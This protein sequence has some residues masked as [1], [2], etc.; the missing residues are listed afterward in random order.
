MVNLGHKRAFTLVELLVVIAIVGAL[1]GLLLPAVQA[2]RE[3]ARRMQCSNHM[4]QI[5]LAMHNYHSA[6]NQLPTGY[7]SFPT[8]DGTAPASMRLDSLTW[9]AGPGWGWGA[10]ILPFLEQTALAEQIRYDRPLWDPSQ[11]ELISTK[12][13]TFLCPS[14]SDGDDAFTVQSESGAPLLI[15]GRQIQLGRS[16]YVVSHGQES[17]WDECGA[18]PEGIV[19]DNIYTGSVRTVQINGDTSR[20]ADGPFYRNSKI[21]IRDILDGTTYTIFAGEHSSMIAHKTWVGI[22]PGAF[23]H[24]RIG[25]PENGPESAATMMFVHSGPSGGELDITGF[26]I[27]HP[28]NHPFKHV[29]QMVSQHPG[30]GNVLFGDGSVRFM[31][32]SV[33]QLTFAEMSSIR[34]REVVDPEKL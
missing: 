34:E 15:D 19:F 25:T 20:V 10:M 1:V 32:E 9:D 30:G 8:R 29:C 5:G 18:E 12:V 22:V 33:N 3:A 28:I 21:G 4:K 16:H 31:T 27:M 23:T 6:F 24:P 14:V 26:P 11:A 13:S 17:C 2:A 7:Y